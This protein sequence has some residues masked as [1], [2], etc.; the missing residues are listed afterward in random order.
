[1][2][3]SHSN[4]VIAVQSGGRTAGEA[5]ALQEETVACGT[6]KHRIGE[7]ALVSKNPF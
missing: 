6:E 3:V 4:G 5:K 2:C 7:M 1:M